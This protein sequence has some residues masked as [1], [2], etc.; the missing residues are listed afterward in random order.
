MQL[1]IGDSLTLLGESFRVKAVLPVTGTIDDGRV[2]AHL[3]TVQAC[4][5]AGE[6][7]SAIEVMGCCEDAAGDL[8]PQLARLLPDAKVVTVSHVVAAQVGVNRLLARSSVFVLGVLVI[9]GG[10]TVASTTSANVRE[11]RREIG[12]LLALGATPRFVARLFLLK[13]AW[14]GLAGGLTGCLVGG[15]AAVALGP[16]WAGVAIAPLPGLLIFAAASVL[17]ITLAA[18]WWPARRAARL[19][20]CT[21][22]REI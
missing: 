18:A 20:P 5:N 1:K 16:R 12:T 21:C 10:A 19:D 22:F 6:V 8:V 4:A 7:V 3:H 11:R 15:A 17:A 13:A 9:V 14:L 2:F